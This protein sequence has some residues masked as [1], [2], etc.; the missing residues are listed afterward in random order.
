MNIFSLFI[1]GS[2][3]SK[4]GNIIIDILVFVSKYLTLGIKVT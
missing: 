4:I 3:F 2:I 1:F